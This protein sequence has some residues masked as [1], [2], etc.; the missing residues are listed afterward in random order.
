MDARK[1]DQ[2]AKENGAVGQADPSTLLSAD[3]FTRV[4]KFWKKVFR[5]GAFFIQGQR[6]W[7]ENEMNKNPFHGGNLR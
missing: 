6:E 2:W 3:F 5:S 4:T 1:D 7:R